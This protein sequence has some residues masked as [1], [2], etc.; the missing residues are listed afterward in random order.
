MMW[1]RQGISRVC[2]SVTC[3]PVWP[4]LVHHLPMLPISPNHS[5]YPTTLSAT[6]VKKHAV[7]F[8]A[9]Q[10][11]HSCRKRLRNGDNPRILNSAPPHQNAGCNPLLPWN[12]RRDGFR[13]S[14]PPLL[15]LSLIT[16]LT[17]KSRNQH[18]ISWRVFEGANFQ[19]TSSHAS[20]W[21]SDVKLCSGEHEEVQFTKI[22]LS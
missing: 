18:M 4:E 5:Y 17:Q 22:C 9:Y 8:Y 3:V 12:R 15:V 20:V 11:S 16:W 13:H 1:P 7:W 2:T 6:P 21:Y 14:F 10:A 19:I